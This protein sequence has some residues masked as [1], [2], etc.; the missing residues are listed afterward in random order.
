MIPKR[1]QL[2]GHSI[3]VS[4]VKRMPKGMSK[5]RGFWLPGENKI[6]VKDIKYF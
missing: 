2:L 3:K 5:A 4:R 1:F 6:Y